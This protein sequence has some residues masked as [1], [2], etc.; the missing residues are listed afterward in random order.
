M[1]S[2]PSVDN[3]VAPLGPCYSYLPLH[4]FKA[5]MAS[6]QHAFVIGITLNAKN[7]AR[8]DI[9]PSFVKPKGSTQPTSMTF[10]SGVA[11]RIELLLHIISP[12]TL[13]NSYW[14]F[15]VFHELF[16]LMQRYWFV[17][18]AM[19]YVFRRKLFWMH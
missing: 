14:S 9:K 3:K 2:F 19:F 5:R 11:A 16:V 18:Y 13:Q 7:W 6:F 8:A 12:C 4:L 17:F 15:S 1:K 10:A